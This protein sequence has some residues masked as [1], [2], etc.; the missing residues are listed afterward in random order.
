MP[1]ENSLQEAIMFELTVPEF[2]MTMAACLFL[3]GILCILSGVY[4]LVSK[5]MM[6][7]LRAVT[8]QVAQAFPKRNNGRSLWFGWKCLCLIG[9]SDTTGS[10]GNRSWD[11]F[12][13]GWFF[14]GCFLVLSCS[15]DQ[16]ISAGRGI[17][18]DQ[19]PFPAFG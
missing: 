18:E 11:V 5:V 13:N 2:M 16:I 10:Y 1:P 3:M 12:G 19:C 8:K 4:I 15:S 14:T 7:E 9:S 17:S 6:G